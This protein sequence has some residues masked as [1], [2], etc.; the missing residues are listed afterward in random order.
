[1][2]YLNVLCPACAGQIRLH[3]AM[4]TAYCPLCGDCISLEDA[5]NERIDAAVLENHPAEVLY[6]LAREADNN[7]TLMH[8]AAK[9]GSPQANLFVGTALV[10]DGEYSDALPFLKVA[11][12]AK[13]PE[14]MALYGATLLDHHNDPDEYEE[15]LKLLEGALKLGCEDSVENICHDHL[16]KLRPVVEN[17]RR[18]R[19]MDADYRRALR[20]KDYEALERLAKQG[21][22]EARELVDSVQESLICCYYQNGLC[23]KQSTS[24]YLAHCDDPRKAWCPD[25][26]QRG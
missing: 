14:G 2:G 19:Q 17:N 16:K 18:V 4:K 9:K 22:A 3:E 13:V 23:T 20:N 6:N 26:R 10:V 21:H 15:I 24:Y 7:S 25:Y 1:M 12:D 11:A 5:K 8:A